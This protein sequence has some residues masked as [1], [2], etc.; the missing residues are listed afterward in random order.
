MLLYLIPV[1]IIAIAMAIPNHI[2][3]GDRRYDIMENWRK[4]VTLVS[5]WF[6][7]FAAIF[8]FCWSSDEEGWRDAHRKAPGFEI[9][10]PTP[11]A[12]TDDLG[13]KNGSDTSS[14]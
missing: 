12:F 2:R 8:R 10:P 3:S 1:A 9:L 14:K 4:I 13:V 7:I 5:L 6:I 11:S